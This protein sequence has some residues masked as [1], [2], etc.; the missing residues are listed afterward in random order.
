MTPV[1]FVLDG[2]REMLHGSAAYWRWLGLLSV[3]FVIGLVA[4]AG[5]LDQ[6]LVV[7]GMSD[8]VSWGFYISNFAFLVG[9]AAAAVLLVIPAYL[10]HRAD[11]K[12]VVLLGEGLAV[13][14]VICA[15]MFVLADLGHPERAWH[16]IPFIG[17]F[18]WSCSTATW[19]S[20]SRCRSMFT[21]ATTA[22][23]SRT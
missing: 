7:T 21:T 3:L 10:F 17:R 20:T 5:Q 15:M 4:Y 6:G 11:V 16:M 12:Q 8:Q 18:N 19:R 14:A 22:G 1:H 13:A 2:V 9:I 23:A